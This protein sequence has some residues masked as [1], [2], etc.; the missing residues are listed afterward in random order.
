[1]KKQTINNFGQKLNANQ[2][3]D[4]KALNTIK[5]GAESDPPPFGGGLGLSD[6]PPFG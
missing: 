4:Q 3:I 1:M 5:G 6:P 2:I